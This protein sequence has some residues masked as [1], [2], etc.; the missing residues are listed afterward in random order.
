MKTIYD[1]HKL[2]IYTFNIFTY[3]LHTIKIQY[4]AAAIAQIKYFSKYRRLL[5][6]NQGCTKYR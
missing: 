5:I 2:I 3:I 6:I 1:L 4:H